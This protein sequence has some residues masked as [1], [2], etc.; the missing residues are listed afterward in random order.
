MRGP[1]VLELE[2]RATS[3]K[4]RSRPRGRQE[5]L[6]GLLGQVID[7]LRRG[8][9]PESMPACPTSD[10]DLE[11]A[12]HELVQ[13][14]LT[15]K[16]EQKRLEASPQEAAIVDAW[17]FHADLACLREQNRRLTTLLNGVQESAALF[18][19]DG[20]IL[21]CNPRAAEALLRIAGIPRAEIIG[22]T[23]D[24]LGVP[25]E[26]LLGRPVAALVE[27]A[28]AHESYEVSAWGRTREAQ[29]EAIYRPDGNVG[30]VAFLGR[31]IHSRKMAQIR[32]DLLSKLGALLGVLDY[33]EI[34][35]GLALVPI[36]QLADWC[37]FN[38]VENGRI[39]RSFVANRDP[40]NDPLRDAVLRALSTW[41]RHPLWQ[42]MLAG[43][44]QLLSQVSDDLLRRLS[45]N[46][47][48]HRLLTRLGVQSLMII[49]LVS[50]AQ[51]TGILTFTYTSQSGRRYGD[52]DPSVAQE[53]AFHAARALE[54]A[55]LVRE[56][57]ASEA[58]FRVALA[59]A[60]TVV[61]EQDASLRYL[62]YYNPLR[63]GKPAEETLPPHEA[64]KL[65]EAK[66]QVIEKGEGVR[67]ELDLTLTD[68][69]QRHYRA[70]IEPVRDNSGGIVGIIG[71]ATDITEQQRMRQQLA[72]DV[73]FR[74]R[75]MEVLSHDL[76]NPL[77]TITIAQEVLMRQPEL[78]SKERDQLLRIRR[79]AD[80]M[81]EM[82]ETLLDATRF[83]HLGRVPVTPARADLGELARAVVD[84]MRA[85][86]PERQVDFTA[87]GDLGGQWD[88]AR[89][90][91]VIS[92]LVVNAISY[93]DPSTP[94]KIA[95]EGDA[96]EVVVTVNNRGEPI[97]PSVVP[98]IFEPFR[99]GVSQ[100][101][102]PHGLGLGLYIVQQ[103][104]LAHGGEIGVE[105][106]THDG[107]TFRVRL[108]RPG[109]GGD[110]VSGGH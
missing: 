77:N 79:S 82:I 19:P 44:Y 47:E 49:P 5:R 85:V 68:D 58:R 21:Y 86:R 80:R 109:R 51:T 92:N 110:P 96:R 64:A 89:V 39:R 38:I 17:Q 37:T 43:G 7:A 30:A 56:L 46:E 54:N 98:V 8:A 12:E 102:S 94:V 83:R 25:S 40:L 76:R 101:H 31:D 42:D 59:G 74:E 10:P 2:R 29:L 50:R 100:D 61:F 93:G 32:V 75:M 65:A 91:Q 1:L 4:S 78:P 26:L 6:D 66:R 13:R 71:A 16:I 103:I 45:S 60:R 3:G 62:W 18:D 52:E 105:S 23:P 84:E 97:A 22:R 99:R 34:A 53:L 104:V 27:L 90:S 73:T 36:P 33:D 28:R 55:R 48:E 14:H 95:L 67:G 87:H 108:P 20:R 88:P 35:E 57:K 106:N 41:D 72:D 11:L 15:E 63:E 70:A 69:E 24:E 107:T 9:P 81:K